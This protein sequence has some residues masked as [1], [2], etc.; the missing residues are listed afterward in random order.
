MAELV[1]KH[2]NIFY[3]GYD[4]TGHSNA[5][6]LTYSAE[7]LDRTTFC[8]SGRKRK[9]GLR[10]IEFTESGFLEASSSDPDQIM[11]N[12]VGS[13]AEVL[14]LC[15]NKSS[16]GSR[17]FSHDGVAGEYAPGGTVGELLGFN[18]TAYGEGGDLVRGVIAENGT[19]LSTEL[20]AT[21]HNLGTGTST[22]K[23]HA[24][25]HILSVSSS[26]AV[27]RFAI[28]SDNSS[29]FASPTTQLVLTSITDTGG[30]V[31]QWHTTAASTV[32]NWYRVNISTTNNDESINGKLFL[33]LL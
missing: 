30:R 4:F 1:L 5:V 11:F 18:F 6:T 25:L 26:G 23:L 22:Q 27:L 9:A 20:T 16:A 33:G 3:G 13:S 17:A 15:P 31:G 29:G 19:A 8:S 2:A 32:D 14:T 12:R 24:A 7:M 28:Q 21:P 10:N